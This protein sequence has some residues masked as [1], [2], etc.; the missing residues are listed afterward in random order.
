MPLWI[1]AAGRLYIDESISIPYTNLISGLSVVA[2]PCL[3]GVLLKNKKPKYADGVAKAVK[4]L[5][6]VFLLWVIIVGSVSNSYIFSVM[7][8]EWYTLP[9]GLMLPYLGALLG[10][11]VATVLCQSRQRVI[12]ISVETGV[13]DTGVAILLLLTSFGKPEGQIASAVPIAAAIF[14]PVPFTIAAICK[15]IYSRCWRAGRCKC[16]GG[17]DAPSKSDC[18]EVD[19]EV[20]FTSLKSEPVDRS[21]TGDVTSDV[22]D[23]ITNNSNHRL[24]EKNKANNNDKF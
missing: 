11:V 24:L 10:G 12:A 17:P 8:Q 7:I 5:A 9:A 23:V 6:I 22:T 18:C 3:L 19:E 14:T 20:V 16:C 1:F 13:Q 21:T 2:V 15:L 4:Y